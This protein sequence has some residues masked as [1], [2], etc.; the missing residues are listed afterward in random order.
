MKK[1]FIPK[2]KKTYFKFLKIK[3]KNKLQFNLN[4]QKKK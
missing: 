3:L 2:F 4:K 1:Q